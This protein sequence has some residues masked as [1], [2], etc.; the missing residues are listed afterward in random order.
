MEATP[1]DIVALILSFVPF[2]YLGNCRLVCKK[3][4]RIIDQVQ[5]YDN[6]KL[7]KLAGRNLY[8][9]YLQHVTEHKKVL[10]RHY[11]VNNYRDFVQKFG[12]STPNT[13]VT[14]R[15][16]QGW[17]K[18]PKNKTGHA[19]LIEKLQIIKPESQA[20]KRKRDENKAE[21][22]MRYKKAFLDKVAAGKFKQ[23]TLDNFP[24]TNQLVQDFFQ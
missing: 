22:M 20:H 13:R 9:D 12:P 10:S 3:W 15:F 8:E 1:I 5:L 24:A 7:F 11:N 21:T 16:S 18:S 4:A 6:F 2:D 14:M 23:L 19:W 17:L